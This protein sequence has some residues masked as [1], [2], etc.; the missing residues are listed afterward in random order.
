[1][2][3][4]IRNNLNQSGMADSW[5]MLTGV[6]VYDPLRGVHLVGVRKADRRHCSRY[7][8]VCNDDVALLRLIANHMHVRWMLFENYQ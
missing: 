7:T 4:R 8:F 5:S 6:Y 1:M 3:L 2:C